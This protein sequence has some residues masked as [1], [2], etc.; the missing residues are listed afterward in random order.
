M[1]SRNVRNTSRNVQLFTTFLQIHH[2]ISEKR[3]KTTKIHNNQW[4]GVPVPV[5]DGSSSTNATSTSPLPLYGVSK[6]KNS[7]T[8]CAR[9]LAE[10]C[11]VTGSV[12]SFYFS[13]FL[14]FTTTFHPE[15]KL[16]Q[17]KYSISATKC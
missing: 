5:T 13:M 8:H 9:H 4:Y 2:L 11:Y 3:N 1:I 6:I 10:F 12:R 17:R 15:N 16:K 14:K 7:G